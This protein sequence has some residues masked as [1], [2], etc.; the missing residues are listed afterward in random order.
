I[1][2]SPISGRVT[3]RNAAPGL[4]VQAGAAPAPFAVADL[5]TMWLIANVEEADISR[6]K[7]GQAVRVKV[8]ALP[9]RLFQGA[10]STIGA[11]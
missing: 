8:M 11:T 9:D 7:V 10:V 6:F 4:F 3:L 5:S 2:H 1:I